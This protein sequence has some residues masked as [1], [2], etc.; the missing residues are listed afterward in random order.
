M[1]D[2]AILLIHQVLFQGMFAA[3]NLF[4]S[5]KIRRPIRGRN[6]EATVSIAFFAFFI[7]AALYL[8]FFREP[9]GRV[10][11]LGDAPARAAGIAL[12][13]ASLAVSGASLLHLRDSWRV[14]VLEDQKTE[15]VTTGIYRFTR[16]PYFLSYLLLFAGC[17]VL[18]QNAILLGL[19][20]IGFL[21]VHHMIRREE[22]HL[23]A[24]HGDAYLQYRK[25]VSRYLNL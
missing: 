7:G 19:S 10:A 17:T 14:G 5:R 25:R 12:L 2:W 11:I 24:Q 16:N 21:L 8:G 1:P 13:L 9:I 15:L 23:Q 20:G 6:A 18:L 4:L 22:K 3:K